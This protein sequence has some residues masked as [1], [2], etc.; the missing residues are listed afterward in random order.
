MQSIYNRQKSMTL[1]G[2][3]L[4][5]YAILLSFQQISD[6][7][8]FFCCILSTFNGAKFVKWDHKQLQGKNFKWEIA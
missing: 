3:V 7:C 4:L 1:A 2:I 8:M 6:V 5:Q